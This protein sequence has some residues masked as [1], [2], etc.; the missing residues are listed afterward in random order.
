[1]IT[2]YTTHCPKC[3]V[4]ETKLKQKNIDYVEN[5]DVQEMLSLGIKSAPVLVIDGEKYNFAEA[6]KWVN[7]QEVK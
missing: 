2:F 4:L 1:M 3:S 6:V 5:T 7:A